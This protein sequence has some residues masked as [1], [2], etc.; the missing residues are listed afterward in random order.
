MRRPRVSIASL[1][2]VVAVA[3]LGFAAVTVA[4]PI[5]VGLVTSLTW[6]LIV[7]AL[8][9]VLF[10]RGSRRVFWT[11]FALLGWSYLILTHHPTTVTF[12][13]PYLLATRLFETLY[14]IL[15]LPSEDQEPVAWGAG[16]ADLG[17]RS[18]GAF[19]GGAGPV[20]GPGVV[21][22]PDFVQIGHMLEALGWAYLGGWAARYFAFERARRPD[23][24]PRAARPLPRRPDRAESPS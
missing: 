8:L 18:M 11:G 24:Q 19:G 13:R 9:G 6:F 2:A 15:H 20:G 17:L 12:I 23:D 4:S 10:G 3:A 14:P 16:S 1:L 22:L 7:A 5:W 21:V